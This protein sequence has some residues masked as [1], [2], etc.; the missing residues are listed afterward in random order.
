MSTVRNFVQL[1]GNLG[2]K[3]EIKHFE[4]GK[5][6][7]KFS[8]ATSYHYTNKAGEKVQDTQWHN[9]VVWGKEVEFVEKNLD[10]GME[11]MIK[12]RINY[13]SYEDKNGVKRV[14][15]E[16]IAEKIELVEKSQIVTE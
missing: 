15:T 13:N 2:K 6:L 4:S 9:I 10:K 8:L 12:G 14:F 5:S 11:V 3:P 7:A 16:I 1:V